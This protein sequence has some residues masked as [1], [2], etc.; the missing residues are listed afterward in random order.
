MKSHI[1]RFLLWLW[2]C[3]TSFARW[4]EFN[5]V[6]KMLLKLLF[7]VLCAWLVKNIT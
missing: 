2:D 7:E 6:F 5:G 3:L 1:K 4:C